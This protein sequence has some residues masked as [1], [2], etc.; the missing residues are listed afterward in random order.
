M[1]AD[2]PL[3]HE[4]QKRHRP[5]GLRTIAL[6]VTSRCNMTC[7]HCY[8]ETFNR[9]D[10]VDMGALGRALE[11]F[12][13]LGVLHY[14]IQG[15]EPVT[16]PKRLEFVL[17]H[18]HP[19]ETYINVVSNG[20]EMDRDRIRWLKD[21]KVDKIAFSLDSG[22][23]EEHD[24]NRL[25][26]SFQRVVQAIDWVR[27]AGLLSSISIVVTHDSLYSEGFRRAYDLARSKGIRMDVQ[28]AEPVGKWDGRKDMLITPEDAAYIKHLQQT[29]GRIST[30][31]T[32]INRDI[33]CG[34]CDHCPAGIE[35]MSLSANGHLLPCNFLQFSLGNIR[36]RSIRQMRDSLMES[37]WFRGEVANCLCGEN[38]DFIDRYIVPYAGQPKP[39]DAYAVFGLEKPP[40]EKPLCGHAQ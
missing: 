37:S 4:R 1:Y 16:S 30:G 18:C 27:E 12:Y 24:A 25:P 13:T 5:G 38:D 2:K 6:D 32:M 14:V 9:V 17:R 33:Y 39:L 3:L 29:S 22:I 26:G 8:A 7:S 31:Q 36:D 10:M 40:G 35:F 19:D 28:I 15:G 34:D 11:E 21:L 20:W 23:Q